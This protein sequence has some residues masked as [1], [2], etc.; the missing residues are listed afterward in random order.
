MNDQKDM[1]LLWTNMECEQKESFS[2]KVLLSRLRRREKELEIV[3][4]I[5]QEAFRAIASLIV[6]FLFAGTM[7]LLTYGQRGYLAFG[8]EI[9]L[10]IFVS[11]CFWAWLGCEF[12]DIRKGIEN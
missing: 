4:R 8:G 6:F 12:A 10:S 11:F 5:L 9:L 2:Q 3:N 1:P 7:I